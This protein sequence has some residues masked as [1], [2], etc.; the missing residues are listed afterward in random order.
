MKV[1][2][3]IATIMLALGFLA[4]AVGAFLLADVSATTTIDEDPANYRGCREI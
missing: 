3:R 2:T 4:K 1:P